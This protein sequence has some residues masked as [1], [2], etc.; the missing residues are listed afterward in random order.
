M[1][2]CRK[3]N[4]V[5]YIFMLALMVRKKV[6]VC[7]C[8]CLFLTCCKTVLLFRMLCFGNSIDCLMA[9][10]CRTNDSISVDYCCLSGEFVSNNALVSL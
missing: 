2:W 5:Y 8:V 10:D 7:V 3:C 6:F 1:N 4:C 9:T